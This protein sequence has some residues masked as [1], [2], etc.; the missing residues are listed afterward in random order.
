[1]R[2]KKIIGIFT[3]LCL[4]FTGTF[5]GRYVSAANKPIYSNGLDNVK[6]TIHAGTEENPIKI[7]GQDG[8]EHIIDGSGTA[9][10]VIDDAIGLDHPGFENQPKNPKRG[11]KKLIPLGDYTRDYSEDLTLPW[12]L[13]HGLHVAGII[14]G[15]GRSGEEPD[16]PQYRG[17]APEA[18]IIFAKTKD[19]YRQIAN[20]TDMARAI[21]DSVAN[22]ADVINMSL[23]TESATGNGG[24]V[25]REAINRAVANG[26]VVVATT[27]NSGY[28]GYPDFKP[29]AENPDY[30]IVASPSLYSNVL[31]TM[32]FDVEKVNNRYIL[33]DDSQRKLRVKDR[34]YNNRN[35][36]GIED[37]KKD[38]IYIPTESDKRYFV[39][40]DFPDY[41]VKDKFIVL[42]K[43]GPE[44]AVTEY[45]DV[46]PG[47][48]GA[49]MI[50]KEKGA[51]G[52]ILVEPK[53]MN[54]HPFEVIKVWDNEKRDYVPA[55][56]DAYREVEDFP[57]LGLTYEDGHALIENGS[58]KMTLFSEF[59]DI[60]IDTGNE[61]TDFSSWGTSSDLIFKPDIGGSSGIGVWSFSNYTDLDGVRH[62]G[63]IQKRGTSMAAP[64]VS[65]AA[66]MVKQRLNLQYPDLPKANTAHLIN[67]L[68]MST[69]KPMKDANDVYFSP[70]GQGNGILQIREACLTDVITKSTEDSSD[71]ETGYAKTNLRTI[72]NKVEFTIDLENYGLTEHT[73]SAPEITVLTDNIENGHLTMTS[74][75]I[76]NESIKLTYD[77]SSI[78]VPKR[79]GN[80]PGKA[81]VRISFDLSGVDADL[82]QAAPNGYWIDGIVKFEGDVDIYHTFTGFKG[83]WTG[84]DVYEKFIYDFKGEDKPFYNDANSLYLTGFLTQMGYDKRD[85]AIKKVLGEL[86]DSEKGNVRATRNRLAI[87]P[88]DDAYADYIE[89]RFVMLRN[90]KSIVFNVKDAS[91]NEVFHGE[92]G[93]GTTDNGKNFSTEEKPFTE[94]SASL[95]WNGKIKDEV[96]E[97]LYKASIKVYKDIVNHVNPITAKNAGEDPYQEDTFDL[98]VD[99]TP[100]IL[101]P[102]K[103]VAKDGGNVTFEI[104]AQDK[105]LKNT[106]IDGSG[107][108]K[109]VLITSS[110]EEE[111]KFNPGND[112]EIKNYRKVLSEEEFGSAKIKLMDWA[113]NSATYDLSSVIEG[114]DVGDISIKSILKDDGSE[115]DVSYVFENVSNGKV[116]SFYENLPVG[117]Y[118]VTPFNI[119]EGYVLVDKDQD[120]EVVIEKGKSVEKVF[121]Y[122]KSEKIAKIVFS[123]A[124]ERESSEISRTN[125]VSIHLI[126]V[127]N[128]ISYIAKLEGTKYNFSVPFG[129]YK[130]EFT[131]Q[132]DG[133]TAKAFDQENVETKYIKAEGISGVYYKYGFNEQKP[134]EA[135]GVTPEI[136]EHY[137]EGK[138]YMLVSAENNKN[139]EIYAYPTSISEDDY[140]LKIDHSNPIVING[141]NA[142]ITEVPSLE[143]PKKKIYHFELNNDLIEKLSPG[144]ILTVKASDKDNSENSTTSQKYAVVSYN[145]VLNTQKME[146]M[147]IK[148]E[149]AFKKGKITEEVKNE[150]NE[151]IDD[152]AY[153]LTFDYDPVNQARAINWR[154]LDARAIEGLLGSKAKMDKFD[155]DMKEKLGEDITYPIIY[156]HGGYLPNVK[157]IL[158][159]VY[160]DENAYN[161]IGD[162]TTTVIADENAVLNAAKILKKEAIADSETEEDVSFENLN[163]L[164]M[165]PIT[166]S[167][168]IFNSWTAKN[169]EVE[170]NND[171]DNA[172]VL[173]RSIS[174]RT[175]D[176]ILDADINDYGNEKAELAKLEEL[177]RKSE[178]SYK[179]NKENKDS[180]ESEMFNA[181]IEKAKKFV[182]DPI[183]SLNIIKKEYAKL[184]KALNRFEAAKNINA[185]DEADK[186]PPKDKEDENPKTPNDNIGKVDP[187]RGES[188]PDTGRDSRPDT[189]DRGDDHI[190]NGGKSSVSNKVNMNKNKEL[191]NTGDEL[192]FKLLIFIILIPISLTALVLK[193]KKLN[194]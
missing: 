98:K 134:G 162:F 17:I 190:G 84:L 70:R 140:T 116:Y 75:V 119:P 184:E 27:G 139:I 174:E 125:N 185:D 108:Y 144:M 103:V 151:T 189:K 176:I 34:Q 188:K 152:L 181:R 95:R 94:N 43:Y 42:D 118:T 117:E 40:E 85:T 73:F 158:F 126:N 19:Q 82:L 130:I 99:I 91:E 29:K 71:I 25:L 150:I 106:D 156:I 56:I 123:E 178:E 24:G 57:I 46:Y 154:S 164:E 153:D 62:Y 77:K 191:P 38:Y 76:D 2:L 135:I 48:T 166:K 146:Y 28:M 14:A 79:E 171:E 97:G 32:C 168:K 141:D 33:A 41:Q 194:S 129:V 149:E 122:E 172:D 157:N 137:Y 16:A 161:G 111:L 7:M 63:L 148:A 167:F 30:G 10:A 113:R 47:Y 102:I 22:G 51:L 44:Y 192:G 155:R 5:Q 55:D 133:L 170:N 110:G 65:A 83:D 78:V 109:A 145:E 165:L 143:N 69:A 142:T 54:Y 23:G 187:D 115:I 180:L 50:L 81:S 86:P 136:V 173:F 12:D 127:K 124:V 11:T 59:T 160:G 8:M 6:E 87:S 13:W 64:Q 100:P 35:Y 121:E 72:G 68:L 67:N 159:R 66:A 58:G 182:S 179:T 88:N 186:T 36:T 39:A 175:A 128:G 163:K 120:Q 60:P 1:M 169:I 21:D 4:L 90:F 18:Q 31:S 52:V 138:T 104:N 3:V 61:I 183:M 9:V 132:K 92:Y 89:P 131:N 80:T 105:K 20:D 96:K 26:V 177:I 147:R 74:K 114:Q 101:K 193:R 93:T 107:I 37:K 53:G 45:G 15:N 112:S 49:A